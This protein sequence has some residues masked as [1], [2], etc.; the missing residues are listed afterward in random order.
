ML[1]L[2]NIQLYHQVLII[3]H[4]LPTLDHLTRLQ[5]PVEVFLMVLLSAVTGTAD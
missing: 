3:A 5:I 4:M 1:Y 2:L